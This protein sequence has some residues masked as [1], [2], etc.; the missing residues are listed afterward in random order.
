[1]ARTM[2]DL[3][4]RLLRG[5]TVALLALAPTL[6]SAHPMG[7]LSTNR[8]ALLVLRPTET[9]LRYTIDFAEVP[10][11]AETERASSLGAD[12]YAAA[13]MSE[14]LP[15]LHLS[16][17][18]ADQPLTVNRCFESGGR[19]EGGLPTVLLICELCADAIHAGRVRL[20][21]D[22]F[23]GSP[24]WREMRVLGNGVD[25]GRGDPAEAVGEGDTPLPFGGTTEEMTRTSVEAT[26]GVSDAATVVTGSGTAATR[27]PDPL[28]A[29]VSATDLSSRFIGLALLSALVLGAGHALSPGHGKTVVAA[30]LVGSRGTVLQALLLGL[31]VTATHVSSVL[32]LGA[33]TLWLSQYVVAAELYPWIGVASGAGVIAVGGGLLRSRWKTWRAYKA[34]AVELAAA[35]I[36]D[37]RHHHHGRAHG[38]ETGH[39]PGSS[40]TPLPVD[41]GG[42]L[43][44]SHGPDGHE[45]IHVDDAG[46][47]VSLQRLLML[48]I[49]G[50]AVP[51]PS[52]LV[53][54]LAAIALHRILFGML[55]IIS[56]SVGLAAVLMAIGVLV[57][58]AQGLLSRLSGANKAAAWLPVASAC[59][60]MLLGF[61]I[62]FQSA[63]EGGLI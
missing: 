4:Q 46:E 1:M 32:L 17:D 50:G 56:F 22:N 14:L 12:A 42:W 53:V 15:A 44:H 24:G 41:N 25:V 39:G 43:D 8:S 47:P 16:V 26:A 18:G 61:G 11:V 9:A 60:V 10:S 31:T 28:A 30:Y 48:G 7:T 34:R 59:V 55:L 3:R 52:A 51:C 13:R 62:A 40:P 23:A 6:A 33:V 21:D 57:V 5:I 38:H 45:H 63:R 29:L 20:E 37:D 35:A 19:G 58:R 27:A 54:L 36:T 2:K 49:T